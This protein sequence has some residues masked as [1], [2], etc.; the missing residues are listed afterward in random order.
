[1]VRPGAADGGRPFQMWKRL[2]V[3]WWCR[4]A[5]RRLMVVTLA[6]RLLYQLLD[7]KSGAAMH[8]AQKAGAVDVCTRLLDSADAEQ[9]PHL[10]V[11]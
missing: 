11:A 6:L 2:R 5:W 3:A 1:M 4:T 8:E 10:P 9:L 7:Q